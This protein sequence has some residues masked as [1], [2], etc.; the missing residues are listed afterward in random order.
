MLGLD[1]VEPFPVPNMPSR[2]QERPSTKIPLKC[3]GMGE[4]ET[5]IQRGKH[6][7]I[8]SKWLH[9]KGDVRGREPPHSGEG[10]EA[11]RLGPHPRPA[12]VEPAF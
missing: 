9:P 4:R 2:T 3:K 7:E 12:E 10:S 11:P 8:C 6:S 1:E 5:F